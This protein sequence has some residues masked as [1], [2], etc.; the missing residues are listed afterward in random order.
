MF[1]KLIRRAAG[2]PFFPESLYILSALGLLAMIA[3]ALDAGLVASAREAISRTPLLSPLSQLVSPLTVLKLWWVVWLPLALLS[4]FLFSRAW[5]GLV[6]PLGAANDVG[7]ALSGAKRIPRALMNP[8]LPVAAFA[9]I[10]FLE[11]SFGMM[12]LPPLSGAFFLLTFAAAFAT[13]LVS[14]RR[15]F[16]KFICPIGFL[17]GISARLAPFRL[18][19]AQGKEGEVEQAC[20]KSCPVFLNLGR[21]S[22]AKDCLLCLRCAKSSHVEARARF[23]GSELLGKDFRPVPSESVFIPLLAGLFIGMFA[24]SPGNYS[25]LN[26]VFPLSLP[27]NTIALGSI[28]ALS[29]FGFI[30]FSAAAAVGLARLAGGPDFLRFNHLHSPLVLSGLLAFSGEGILAW[31]GIP[32]WGK[33]ALLSLGLVWSALLILAYN[34]RP[35]FAAT[36]RASAPAL[37]YAN[38]VFSLLVWASLQ[39]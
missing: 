34:A 33:V 5:C 37:L 13:G 23:P 8:W 14:P 36:L 2:T 15:S 9:G 3:L 35:G 1:G 6:C 17:F 38:L 31:L 28:N 16:C 25:A 26:A 22:T 21:A 11:R 24:L 18:A 10:F 4:V 29:F 27:I 20:G 30:L 12:G 39:W 19:P 32:Y 7:S